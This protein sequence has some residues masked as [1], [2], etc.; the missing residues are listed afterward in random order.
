MNVFSGSDETVRGFN[1]IV[2]EKKKNN[3]YEGSKG[4]LNGTYSIVG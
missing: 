3:K 1:W 4:A 2:I